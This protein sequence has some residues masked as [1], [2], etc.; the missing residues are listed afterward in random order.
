[1]RDENE[2]PDPI[3][4]PIDRAAE[5]LGCG[6]TKIYELIGAEKLDARKIDGRTVITWESIK[7]CAKALPKADIKPSRRRRAA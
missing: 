7:E 4:V 3:N 2:K 1:M 6:R 5:A